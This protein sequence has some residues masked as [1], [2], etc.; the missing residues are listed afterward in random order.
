MNNDLDPDET[1]ELLVTL[2]F[3][4][5]VTR[6][7]G[8]ARELATQLRERWLEEPEQLSAV[9]DVALGD[10]YDLQVQPFDEP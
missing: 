10:E 4:V 6:V 3:P 7:D 1:T 5:P 8:G 9:L 2:S